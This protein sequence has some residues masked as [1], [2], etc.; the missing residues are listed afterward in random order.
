MEERLPACPLREGSDSRSLVAREATRRVDQA[1]HGN[2]HARHWR[3]SDR[4][5]RRRDLEH[6]ALEA[7]ARAAEGVEAAKVGR[8]PDTAYLDTWRAQHPGCEL[9]LLD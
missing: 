3:S 5:E 2:R 8:D 7:V 1:V 4:E 6:A 9:E